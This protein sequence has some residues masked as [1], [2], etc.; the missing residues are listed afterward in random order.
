[1]Q[2]FSRK[3]KNSSREIVPSLLLSISSRKVAQSCVESLVLPKQRSHS[4]FVMKPSPFWVKQIYQV[5]GLERLGEL[6][7]REEF[8]LADGG[9]EVLCVV[10]LA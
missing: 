4:S 9:H 6:V 5:E 3:L 10:D 2:V 7:A 1:M 8:V